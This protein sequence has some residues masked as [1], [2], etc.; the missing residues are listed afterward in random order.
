M[1][2][3]LWVG[4]ITGVR[5]ALPSVAGHPNR[6]AVF[7]AATQALCAYALRPV[8]RPAGLMSHCDNYGFVLRF[9]DY[10]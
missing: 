3:F 2:V 5:S 8:A 7:A 4:A 10:D 6:Y 1:G 9:D